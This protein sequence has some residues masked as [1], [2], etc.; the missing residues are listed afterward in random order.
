VERAAGA[1]LGVPLTVTRQAL[2]WV[3]PPAGPD[4]FTLDA[5]FPTWAIHDPDE[6]SLFYGFPL[7]PENPGFKIARHRPG[8]PADPDTVIRH[9]LLPE[10]EDD[11]R[12]GL[13]FFPGAIGGPTLAIRICLYTNSPD[14]HFLVDRHPVC[15]DRVSL[16]CGFSGHGF[17]FA[18]VIGE[19]LADLAERGATDLP[20][21]F[22]RLARFHA[23]ATA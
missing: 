18:P 9:A 23:A 10:D 12:P 5:G 13:R 11:F 14:G 15:P 16:A 22:L 8:A 20:I 17:K 6:N 2:G 3:W 7:L 21:G 1:K 4:G 19:A